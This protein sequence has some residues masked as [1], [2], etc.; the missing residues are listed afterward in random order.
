MEAGDGGDPR[1]KTEVRDRLFALSAPFEGKGV[2]LQELPM[3]FRGVDWGNDH[4][5]LVS[6]ARWSDRKMLMATFDPSKPG[7]PATTRTPLRKS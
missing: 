4:L 7:A 5:A 3:R 6:E 2:V 1:V